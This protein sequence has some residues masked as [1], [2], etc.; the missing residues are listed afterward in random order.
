MMPRA[1]I[2]KCSSAPPEN[3]LAHPNSVP[4]AASKND[5]SAWP[6]MP[7]VG[8]ATPRR[9]TASIR[10]VKISR[11][12]NSGMREA[13]EKPSS[14]AGLAACTTGSA[15]NAR[16]HRL[17]SCGLLC[18]LGRAS[19]LGNL[20]TRALRERVSA[21]V[22]SDIQFPVAKDFDLESRLGKIFPD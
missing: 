22:Q 1:K 8:T 19:R 21:H 11:R 15:L 14:M 17:W 7:G 13:P 18:Q 6:S 12:R 9:Y 2:E 3:R 20:V 16:P 5:A 4:E 10:A